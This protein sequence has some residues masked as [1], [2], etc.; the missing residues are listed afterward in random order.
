MICFNSNLLL[1]DSIDIE[2]LNLM[3][4]S[5]INFSLC[6]ISFKNKNGLFLTIAIICFRKSLGDTN[7]D[8]F[9][10]IIFIFLFILMFL[11]IFN[12]PKDRYPSINFNFKKIILT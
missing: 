5:I 3:N 10:E 12:N 11:F 8:I 6:S 4:G 2:D 7:H 1:I 9:L